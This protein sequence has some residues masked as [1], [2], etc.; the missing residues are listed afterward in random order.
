MFS[1]I[2]YSVFFDPVYNTLVFFIDA[3]PN[4]GVGLS[5]VVTVVVIKLLLLPLSIKATKTQKKIREIEPK[6]KAIKEQ[7]K[8]DREAYTKA[9]MEIYREAGLNPFASIGVMFLQ[10]PFVIALYL[11]VSRGGGVVL[12]NINLDLL[13]SFIPVPETVSMMMFGV[14]DI[15]LK[16]LPLA[17]VAALGQFIVSHFTIPALPQ[18]DADAEPSFKDDL[19]RNL[20]LQMRY[21]MP[22]VIGFV[23]YA[24]SATIAIYFIVSSAMALVQEFIVRKHR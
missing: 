5:I 18:R 10:I 17:I 12:P 24:A 20:N 3:F 19:T 23:A 1:F 4:G 7:Y 16:S 2:W 11:S 22:L 21:M 6:L 13:Y 14:F 15:A 8:D 9:M